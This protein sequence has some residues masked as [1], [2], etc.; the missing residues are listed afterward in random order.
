MKLIIWVDVRDELPDSYKPVIAT[1]YEHGWEQ[2]ATFYDG[3]F[4]ISK[5]P[6]AGR[7]LPFVLAWRYENP[8]DKSNM[9]RRFSNN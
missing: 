9:E 2:E 5:G 4:W 3:Q 6:L 8:D 7:L 1:N